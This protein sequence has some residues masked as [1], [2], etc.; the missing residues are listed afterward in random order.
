M[1]DYEHSTVTILRIRS[2]PITS[3]QDYAIEQD[4][5]N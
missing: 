2:T 1:F 5:Y 4:E 3:I